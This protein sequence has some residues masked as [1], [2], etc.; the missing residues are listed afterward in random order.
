MPCRW[1]EGGLVD[2][3]GRVSFR[4]KF[5]YPGRIDGYERLWLTIGRA[6]GRLR[7]ALNGTPLGASDGGDCEFEVTALLRQRNELTI[8]VDGGESGGLGGE[9]ALEVRCTAFL[10][11]LA[12]AATTDADG[13]VRVVV[14]GELVG[15]AADVLELYLLTDGRTVAYVALSAP[16]AAQPFRLASDPLPPGE[17]PRHVQVDLVRAA[18]VWY[19][20]EWQSNGDQVPLAYTQVEGGR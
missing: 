11:S 5:G 9:V 8:E 19:R 13:S 16:V 18:T 20:W 12:C 2:F 10:R 6:S 3:R 15:T 7:V 17:G 4:R 1:A 14:T